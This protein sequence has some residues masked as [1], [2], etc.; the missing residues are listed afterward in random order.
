MNCRVIC[1]LIVCAAVSQTAF[2]I[3]IQPDETASK[4]V[5][6]YENFPTMNWDAAPF[7]ALLAAGKTTSGHDTESFV[8]FDLSSVPYTAGQVTSA[9]LNLYVVD[10]A[11]AGFGTSPTVA[12]PV[13]VDLFGI[14]G[15]W[16]EARLTWG[17]KPAVSATTTD[18]VSVSGVD[19]WISFDVTSLVVGWLDGSLTNNG[20]SLVADTVSSVSST[21]AV[22]DSSAG[23]NLPY[24]TVVPEPGSFLLALAA[25]PALA[26][27]GVRS[28]R[29]VRRT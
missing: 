20:V 10:T 25:A 3:T 13:L 18:A 28:R 7:G 4:D 19:Q 8:Q 21:A 6:A 29:R 12:S 14:T 9:T 22:F 16:T 2:G 5:F 11:E 26:W 1:S 23:T 17:T 27:L 15:S 24:L